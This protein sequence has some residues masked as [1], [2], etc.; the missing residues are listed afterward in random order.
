M[1]TRCSTIVF[2]VL[3]FAACSEPGRTFAWPTR[4]SPPSTTTAP[5]P[6]PAPTPAP[7]PAPTPPPGPT[8]RPPLPDD[9]TTLIVGEVFIGRVGANPPRCRDGQGVCQFFKVTATSDGILSVLLSF[10]ARQQPNQNI[11]LSVISSDGEFWGA[12]IPNGIEVR[13]PA[14]RGADYYITVWYPQ[15]RAEFALV[16]TIRS[17]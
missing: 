12:Y 8:P 1:L 6:T 3:L 2:A 4:P 10:D 16:A 14:E 7:V 11:D 15:P 9:Y 5:S 13:T 17:E